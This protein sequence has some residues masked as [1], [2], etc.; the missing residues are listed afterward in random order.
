MSVEIR[1]IEA[2]ELEA[3]YTAMQRLPRRAHLPGHDLLRPD[4]DVTARGRL[5]TTA[6]S[7]ARHAA[8]RTPGGQVGSTCRR[9]PD[10]D[11]RGRDPG[12]A[13]CNMLGADLTACRRP[14]RR[15]VTSSPP[16]APTAATAT[17]GERC[18]RSWL[19]ARRALPEVADV[20]IRPADSG[21]EVAPA[22]SGSGGTPGFIDRGRAGIAR[23]LVRPDPSEPWRPCWRTTEAARPWVTVYH[24]EDHW[25]R[26]ELGVEGLPG[27]RPSR[28]L[29]RFAT[30]VDWVT[31]ACRRRTVHE[32]LRWFLHDARACRRSAVTSCGFAADAPPCSAVGGTRHRAS[33]HR[34]DRQTRGRRSP[35]RGPVTLNA[36]RPTAR[37]SQ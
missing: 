10:P 17:G 26:T 22:T 1:T 32:P 20:D 12:A 37:T 15:S 3:W 27:H 16:N 25:K 19:A 31:R 2:D 14:A 24:V 21:R 34:G 29:W 7:S 5:S 18:R 4:F 30:E 11:Y 36:G 9:S 6:A 13:S 33:R 8:W 23:R 28:P 35:R